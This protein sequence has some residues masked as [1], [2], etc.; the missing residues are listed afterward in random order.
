ML[1]RWLIPLWGLLCCAGSAF[2]A[3]PVEG[4]SCQVE[5]AFNESIGARLAP[6]D[7]RSFHALADMIEDGDHLTHHRSTRDGD[8]GIDATYRIDRATL[9]FEAHAIHT[10]HD[11]GEEYSVR[12]SG[13]CEPATG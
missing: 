6:P 8:L 5:S 10:R 13:Q 1:P 4:L 12:E 3:T 11:L 2:A 7:D 9:H